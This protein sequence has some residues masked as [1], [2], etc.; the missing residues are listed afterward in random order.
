LV[1]IRTLWAQVNWK[2]KSGQIVY[3]DKDMEDLLKNGGS[4][5]LWDLMNTNGRVQIGYSHCKHSTMDYGS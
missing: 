1:Y 3:Q 2:V 4:T 5:D